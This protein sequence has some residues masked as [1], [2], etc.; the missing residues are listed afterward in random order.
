MLPKIN[1]PDKGAIAE[2]F[3]TG[4]SVSSP[5]LTLKFVPRSGGRHFRV[6]FIVPKAA[7]KRAV[8]RNM[9]RRRGYRALEKHATA[10]PAQFLGAFI[11]NKKSMEQFGQRSRSKAFRGESITNLENEIEKILRKIN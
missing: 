8:D 2:L 9:L 1:R 5:Y 11:F 4:L 3:S 10:L 7:A 6:S